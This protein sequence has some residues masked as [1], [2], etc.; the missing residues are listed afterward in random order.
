MR[1]RGPMCLP[2][3]TYP[4]LMRSAPSPLPHT[5]TTVVIESRHPP[6]FSRTTRGFKMIR[7]FISLRQM[8]RTLFTTGWRQREGTGGDPTPICSLTSQG[9]S[10]RSVSM[11]GIPPYCMDNYQLTGGCSSTSYR[12]VVLVGEDGNS[13]L[14]TSLI[15]RLSSLCLVRSSSRSH[16][17]VEAAL[18]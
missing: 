11:R 2:D 16:R 17:K 10:H 6:S 12:L 5:T 3:P 1:T 4:T 15:L 14:S 18:T 13:F 9:V 7:H 8:P